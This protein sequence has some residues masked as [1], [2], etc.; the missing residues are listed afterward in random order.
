[1]LSD[2]KLYYRIDEVSEML[3]VSPSKLR[4]WEREISELEPERS[5]GGQRRYTL[6][7]IEMLR[8]IQALSGRGLSLPAIDEF[9]KKYTMPNRR[10]SCNNKKQA[11]GLIRQLRAIVIENPKATAMIDALEKFISRPLI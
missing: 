2:S 8:K 7:T 11:L 10:P 3:G 6:E 9:L 4:W 5:R 1:M